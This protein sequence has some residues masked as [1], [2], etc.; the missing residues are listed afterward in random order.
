ME[1]EGTM[2][3]AEGLPCSKVLNQG[4]LV[5]P[6]DFRKAHWLEQS[7]QGEGGKKIRLYLAP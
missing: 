2:L 1:R 4:V 5:P 7:E 3:P 6:E